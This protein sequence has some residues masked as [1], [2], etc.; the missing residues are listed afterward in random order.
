MDATNTREWP[1][2]PSGEEIYGRLTQDENFEMR[3]EADRTS[4]RNPN[5]PYDASQSRDPVDTATS[6]NVDEDEAHL[7]EPT[8]TYVPLQA[9]KHL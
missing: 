4:H 8:I 1:S 6:H 2:G 3:R 7:M 5:A 9:R